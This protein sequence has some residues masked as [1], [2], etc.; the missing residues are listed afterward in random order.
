MDECRYPPY[1]HHVWLAHWLAIPPPHFFAVYES[2]HVTHRLLLTTE[3]E[4]DVLWATQRTAKTFHAAVGDIGFFPCD[5]DM[6]TLSMTSATGFKAYAL[7]VP[8]DHLCRISASEGLRPAADFR[9]IPAFRDA[10]LAASL[11][12]LSTRADARQVSEDIGD[13]IAARQ[14]ILRLCVAVG[15]RPPD[16]QKDSSVFTPRVMRE[17]VERM[18][19]SLGTHVSLDAM[20]RNVGL[21]PGHFARKFKLSTGVSLDRFLN[22]RRIGVSFAMLR[23]DS[24]PLSSIALA[25]GFSS[26]SHFT[27]LFSRITGITPQRFRRLHL[28]MGT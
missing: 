6:H 14:I 10:L 16:W 21:S 3:G 7:C 12:R 24:S 2:R 11:L 8:D 15:S 4:A 22:M 26:Q 13:D 18:D 25:L 27:S 23:E 5:R 20:A 1:P 28:R 19:A 17:I 9:A